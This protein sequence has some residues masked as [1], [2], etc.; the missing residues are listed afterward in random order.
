MREAFSIHR[1][2]IALE[3]GRCS[4]SYG[5]LWA[6]A[7]AFANA[8]RAGVGRDGSVGI[9]P[10]R[11][12]ESYVAALGAMIMRRPFVSLNMKFPLERQIQIA[13]AAKC[14]AIVADAAT[15]SR[16]DE[17]L[18]AIDARSLGAIIGAEA[19]AGEHASRPGGAPPCYYMFTSGTTG[20]PKGVEVSRDNLA[21]YLD[22][23]HDLLSYPP[24]VRCSQFFDLSFDV[25]VHDLFYTWMSGG[26]LCPM[27][28]DD[29]D[30]V[31]FAKAKRIQAWYSV[32]FLIGI[33]DR[34]GGLRRG[35]LPDVK[36]SLFVGEALPTSLAEAWTQAC[37]NARCFNLYGPTEA[38]I[39][40][41]GH[42]FDLASVRSSPQASVPIGRPYLGTETVVVGPDGSPVTTG[43]P[44]ELW[45]GG[46]QVAQGYVGNVDETNKRFVHQSFEGQKS[47]RWYRTGDLVQSDAQDNYVFMGRIDDQVKIRGYRVEL[48][49]V[50][51]ALR[52]A[53]SIPRVAAVPWP[54]T[55]SGTAAGI[56]GFVCG[57]FDGDQALSVC[58]ER[59]PSYMVPSRILQVDSLPLNQNGK[60]DRKALRATHLESV[61]PADAATGRSDLERRLVKAW[62]E[63]FP[64]RRVS[65]ETTFVSLKGDSLSYV[66]ALL[67]AEDVLGSLPPNWVR[68]SIADLAQSAATK[69]AR[70]TARVD[71]PAV[72][73][74]VAI[75]LVLLGHFG[76][77]KFDTGAIAGLMLLSGFF[78]GSLQIDQVNDRDFARTLIQPVLSLCL[79]YYLVFLPLNFFIQGHINL[80]DALLLQDFLSP[81][82]SYL[83]FIHALVHIVIATVAMAWLART[84]SGG[85]KAETSLIVL[86]MLVG[87]GSLSWL[88]APFLL[89]RPEAIYLDGAARFWRYGFVGQMFVFGCGA[90]LADRGS[91]SARWV[92]LTLIFVGAAVSAWFGYVG[93]AVSSLLAA[94]A[95]AFGAEIRL[96]RT[97][98]R[99]IYGFADATLFIYLFQPPLRALLPRVGVH[100]ALR[101]VAV[102]AAGMGISWTWSRALKALRRRR[103]SPA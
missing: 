43:A 36:W 21:A 39:T 37:P 15:W 30:H 91:G 70:F 40:C 78:F 65:R 54:V 61:T 35:A 33:A 57:A 81:G 83:W 26:V 72:V 98:A 11:T 28:S 69:P 74:A 53:T 55:A 85:R 16:R 45:L 92:G 100:G 80:A 17:I 58:A 97:L 13:R 3:I 88:I 2:S 19:I 99:G 8:H 7:D 87:F 14:R 51:E 18:A 50:E 32:P 76:L 56:V 20:D 101:F 27:T 9:L 59:L 31:A 68:V 77:T 48:A 71:M 38:T 34:D 46:A 22:A 66:S 1:D 86:T 93:E 44:G 4:Y 102:I 41:V 6:R 67:S 49:E 25:S 95:L 73:R 52:A 47:Q 96:P 12:L 89:P 5:D 75:L 94:A 10:M 29:E 64:Q 82:V 84:V 103:H 60:V 24:G 23:T 63:L 90:L 62:S 42:E 79:A